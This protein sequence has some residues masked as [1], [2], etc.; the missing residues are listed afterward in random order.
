MVYPLAPLRSGFPRI[1]CKSVQCRRGVI[2]QLNEA[3]S[4]FCSTSQPVSKEASDTSSQNFGKDDL[5]GA[6]KHNGWDYDI[7]V[8][9]G[10]IVGITFVA[11]VL[12]KTS[13]KLRIGIFSTRHLLLFPSLSFLFSAHL[14]PHLLTTAMTAFLTFVNTLHFQRHH[15]HSTPSLFIHNSRERAARYQGLCVVSYVNKHT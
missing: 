1:L 4:S 13:N 9:G 12:Q 15:R 10:G 14:V 5:T 8:N 11:K 2:G 3:V 6:S 7:L